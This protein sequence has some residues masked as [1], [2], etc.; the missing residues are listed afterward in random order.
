MDPS[1]I[2]VP[3][4]GSIGSRFESQASIDEAKEN[5]QKAWKEAYARIGQEPPPEQAD[6]EYDPRTLFERLQAKKDLKKEE[7]D[8]KMKLSNQ[9]R[10]I[11]SEEQ[12]FLLEKDEEK[13]L[14]QRK[15]EEKE[16]E[17]LREYRE[18]QASKATQIENVPSSSS[19]SSSSN[20]QPKKIPPK[21]IKKDVKSLMKGIIVK[22]KPKST[23]TNT[24][25]NTHTNT[26][27]PSTTITQSQIDTSPKSSS[28]IGTK[29]DATEIEEITIDQ[30]SSKDESDEKRRKVDSTDS[31]T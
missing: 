7:W 19:L 17:E 23:T 16:A 9:W 28:S 26:V 11:D 25:T 22:K 18:R 13:K 31:G 5:K 21:L 4:T 20:I 12:R 24:N 8:S 3:A 6:E 10:G 1:K 30:I 14:N 2:L 29:R 27:I 15:V